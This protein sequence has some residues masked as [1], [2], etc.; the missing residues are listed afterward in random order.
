MPQIEES[1]IIQGLYLVHLK[2]FADERG[3]FIE[4]FRKEW[5]PFRSWDCV[6]TNRSDSRA[7]VLRGLHFH[8]KQVDYWYVS[9]GKIRAALVDLRSSS[10]THLKSQL[11]DLS[12][13]DPT[14]LYIPIGVAHGFLAL[15]DCTLNYL[16]DNYYDSTDEFGLAWDDPQIALQ[17]GTATP[18]ISERDRRNP[19][20][21]D[22]VFETLP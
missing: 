19:R 20:L 12:G 13:D 22:I 2:P 8:K 18:V 9:Q 10:P 15:T 17:W 16:V 1:P 14:G 7:G 11:L 4:T 3:R 21:A 5:F 6:Q